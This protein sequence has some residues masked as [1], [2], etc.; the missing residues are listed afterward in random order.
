MSQDINVKIVNYLKR[1]NPRRIGIFG[2]YARNEEIPQS[3]N[4]ILFDFPGQ[5]SH[6]PLLPE[7]SVSFAQR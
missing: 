3:D 7:G 1:L 6:F 4:D 5:A 2:F